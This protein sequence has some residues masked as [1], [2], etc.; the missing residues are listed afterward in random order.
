MATDTECPI[1]YEELIAKTTGRAELS[2]G[3]A[4]H[5]QCVADWFATNAANTCPMCRKVATA[6]EVPSR[7]GTMTNTGAMTNVLAITAD[8]YMFTYRY[9]NEQWGV[10]IS[11]TNPVVIDIAIDTEPDLPPEDE[12]GLEDSDI[13]LV[14][15]Q[16]N[17]SR[18]RSVRALRNTNGDIVNAIMELCPPATWLTE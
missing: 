2:C 4:Y 10:A 18:R 8:E 7:L 15:Q 13:V 16:A 6:K 11:D 5:I 14:A 1:C 17:V 12:S 9:R 3:H